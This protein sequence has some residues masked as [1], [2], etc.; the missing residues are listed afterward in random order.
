M[1]E[2]FQVSSLLIFI[3][4]LQF[5]AGSLGWKYIHSLTGGNW[6]RGLVN[7]SWN[8]KKVWAAWVVLFFLFVLL[9]VSNLFHESLYAWM[10]PVDL[11]QN[12]HWNHKVEYFS[13]TRVGLR[14][15]VYLLV[16]AMGLFY[17]SR[18]SAWWKGAFAALL[19]L[20]VTWVTMDFLMSLD[21]SWHSSIFGAHFALQS[22]SV[23]LTTSV[24]FSLSR[25]SADHSMRRDLGHLLLVLV[26]LWAYFHLCQ[27]L[28]IWSAQIPYEEDWY[29][30]HFE[31]QG[32]GLALLVICLG[33]IL[34]FFM[35]LFRRIIESPK[36]L[37]AVSVLVL[38]AHIG[39]LLWTILPSVPE[40][41]SI[42]V[43]TAFS[44]ILLPGIWEIRNL[45][46]NHG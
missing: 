15:A 20:V 43:W 38:W 2:I 18:L 23:Y 8:E 13:A 35:L 39:E 3:L 40:A 27:Y 26:M 9:A 33:F 29:R 28:I 46:R 36:G 30:V 4:V 44:L 5:L 32:L 10:K 16:P 34:P 12:P 19:F 14:S 6:Y 41:G 1:L 7:Q 17:F 31:G 24:V 22:L 21:L 25:A 11:I 37:F 45:R 42:Y